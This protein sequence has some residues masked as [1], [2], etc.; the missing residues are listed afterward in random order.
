MELQLTF[1]NEV[2]YG[3]H[4]H[5]IMGG[6]SSN[7]KSK[8]CFTHYNKLMEMRY[9]PFPLALHDIRHYPLLLLQT[10]LTLMIQRKKKKEVNTSCWS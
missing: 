3:S 2:S 8:I 10:N 9:Q 7:I 1:I 4:H 6:L 5:G